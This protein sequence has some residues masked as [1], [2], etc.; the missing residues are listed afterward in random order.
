MK[1]LLITIILCVALVAVSCAPAD[2]EVNSDKYCVSNGD[3]GLLTCSGC[4]SN[5]FLETAPPDNACLQY[6]NF[7]CKCIDHICTETDQ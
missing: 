5:T 7:T 1:I 4:Y 6:E 2:S 3:C